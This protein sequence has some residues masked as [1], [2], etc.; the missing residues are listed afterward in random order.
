MLNANGIEINVLT[1]VATLGVIF[2]M[3]PFH[4]RIIPCCI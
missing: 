4:D 2:G 1:V 3:G